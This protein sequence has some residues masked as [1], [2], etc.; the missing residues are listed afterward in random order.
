MD[1]ETPLPAETKPL[2]EETKAGLEE[3]KDAKKP[4]K[5]RGNRKKKAPQECPRAQDNSTLRLIGNWADGPYKQTSPPTVP[6]SK[7]FEEGKHPAGEIQNYV[8]EN[9]W[10][11]TSEEKRELERM[12][13]VDLD[14]VRKAAECHR[15]V[16]RW[17][18]SV[19]KPGLE[20]H[21]FVESLEDKTR[22]LLEG[23][24]LDAGVG[25]PTGVSLNHCAAHFSPNP[26]DRVVIGYDDVLKVDFGTHINGRIMDCA[27]T[28][29]FNEK[30]D[31]LVRAPK[32]AT[33]EGL[34][35]A[36]IDVRLTDVGAAIQEVM[37][38][39][40]V[41][42]NGKVYPIKSIR[43]LN[44]HSIEPYHIHG[45]KSVPIVANGDNT[46]MEEGEFYAIE[47]FGS[48]GRG[49]V[50]DEGECSHYMID[51]EKFQKPIPI[52]DSKAK[53]LL[54]HIEKKYATLPW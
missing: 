45:G 21:E 34:K 36:G 49:V 25:F 22:A 40:E 20:L 16:R 41:E 39:Y 23:D 42:L 10:R 47:T 18:E 26:G 29:A 7:Q 8:N 46:K 33:N 37:E 38:S 35:V 30:Y 32:E 31:N 13:T 51:Y 27:F 14:S 4:K 24:G 44:G 9:S 28:V 17:A 12:L 15:Q 1:L 19:L 43:N 53:A 3:S 11:T 48:T 54:K 2:P 5:K 50:H 6:I 52:R